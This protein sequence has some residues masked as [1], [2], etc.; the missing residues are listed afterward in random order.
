MSQN[1]NTTAAPLPDNIRT[2]H[3]WSVT[4]TK[5]VDETVT[6]TRN[7][8]EVKVTAKVK[9]P[10]STRMA[11]K[12]P[13]RRELR[14]AELFY[15]TEVNRFMALGFLPRSI[16]VNKH[17]DLTGGVMSLKE[18]TQIAT[19]TARHV[20]LENDLVRT[21]N[22][23]EEVRKGIQTELAGIRAEI[24]NLNTVNEAVFSQTAEVKAQNQ[25]GQWF[26]FNLTYIERAGKWEPYFVGKTFDEKE[27]WTW[28][29][30]EEAD[31][32]YLAAITKILT[33]CHFFNMGATSPEQFKLID[34]ELLKREVPK[35]EPATASPVAA[36][37]VVPAAA[38]EVQ[39]GITAPVA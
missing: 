5:E 28:K 4:V 27:E 25:L 2:L 37:P 14:Q 13:N 23:P 34:E 8:Q 17:L 30:E 3:A 1:P 9:K 12:Q 26:A 6:E 10:V 16:L 32:F 31:Q 33:Y 35:V 21:M 38:Q 24:T 15:G 36:N 7:G 19:L 20:E 39:P 11:L 29:L 22:E 18:R